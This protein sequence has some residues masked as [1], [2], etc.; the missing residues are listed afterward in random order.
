MTIVSSAMLLAAGLG[1]RMRP[2]TLTRPKP[3]VEVG[4]RALIDY[5]LDRLRA[6]HVAKVV[7]N[8]H[9]F[10]EQIESWASRQSEPPIVVSN[11]RAEVLDT[12]GGIKLAL[13]H[14]GPHPFFVLNSDSFWLEQG[15]PALDR[16]SAAWDDSRM[17]C[18]LLLCP[19]AQTVGYD[20]SGDFIT[21]ES[22]RL[23]RRSTSSREALAYIGGYL[24]HP[25][26]FADAPT[27]KFSMNLLW[28]RAIAVRRLHGLVHRG[29]WLHV[30]T[31]ESI[32]L[33][34]AALAD[35]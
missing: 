33:A 11:E 26:L 2:L 16:L 25:R 1:L 17:D 27:G 19:I 13:P 3:L 22:G 29:R 32:A 24:V 8:V 15:Q 9:Y 21:A 14:L 28:D 20:G 5:A 18:L 6:A 34:E 4:G 10:A 30:G 23:Q 12:G 35:G 31:P 7:V